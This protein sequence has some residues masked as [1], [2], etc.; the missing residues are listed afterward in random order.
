MIAQSDASDKVGVGGWGG[1]LE[2]EW[3]VI[4]IPPVNWVCFV[5]SGQLLD[6]SNHLICFFFFMGVIEIYHLNVCRHSNKIVVPLWQTREPNKPEAEHQ[7]SES[8]TVTT[9]GNSQGPGYCERGQSFSSQ[10]TTW[11]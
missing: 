9:L 1:G 10:K 4:P 3:E 11:S 8:E 2:N 6:F 7:F 5:T